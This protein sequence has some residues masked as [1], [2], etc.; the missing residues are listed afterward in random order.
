MSLE[1]AESDSAVIDLDA[2]ADY[3]I[4]NGSYEAASNVLFSIQSA[5]TLLANNPNIGSQ[6]DYGVTDLE[7]LRMLPVPRYPVYLIF[8]Q[9]TDSQL[10]IQRVLHGA[11]DIERIMTDND[12]D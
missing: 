12:F 6:R 10:I 2:I 8:Y 11:R 1:V 3:I 7:G 4:S 5:Y 9:S